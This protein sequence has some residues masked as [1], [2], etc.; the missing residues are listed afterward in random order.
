MRWGRRTFLA[1]LL[2]LPLLA[3]ARPDTLP[4]ARASFGEIAASVQ[5]TLSLPKL[6]RPTDREAIASIDSG[7]DTTLE[8]HVTLWEYSTRR[9]I[10]TRVIVVKIGKNPWLHRY[11]VKTK[12]S[13]GW[14]QRT[15]EDRAEAIEA[16]VTL[17]RIR[18]ADAAD[19]VRGSYEDGPFYFASVL[20]MR[21][22]IKQEGGEHRR[23]RGRGDRDLVWFGRLVE[24]LAGERA[25]AEEIV[26]VKTNIFYLEKP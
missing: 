24:T 25:R 11:V 14:V 16:A 10:S 18:L 15:F 5:M 21:N 6:I 12:G 23:R 19:L 8:Y 17:D 4:K 7:W 13:T 20:A 3:F 26:H 9:R 1:G 22:P 2:A